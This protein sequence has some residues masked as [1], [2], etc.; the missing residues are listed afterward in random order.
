MLEKETPGIAEAV[1]AYG[2]DRT[3]FAMLSR[4]MAGVRGKCLIVNLPGSVR[5][6]FESLDALFPAIM[7]AVA[8]LRGTSDG[9]SDDRGAPK[10]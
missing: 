4:G 3:P 1:R 2:S 7:H 9:H 6:V 8:L 10:S 5:G